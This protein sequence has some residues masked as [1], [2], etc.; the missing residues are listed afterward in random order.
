M[1]TP[2]SGRRAQ[3]ARNDDRI[4]AAARHVFV[5]DPGAPIAAVAERAGVGISALYRRYE[6][7]EA[8]LRKLCGD[9]LRSYIA[10]VE[11]AIA[12]EGDAWEAFVGFMRRVVDADTH[13][14][15]MSLAG[16]FRPT[17]ELYADAATAGRLNEQLVRRTKAAGVLRDDIQ[18]TDFGMIFQMVAAVRLGDEE[19]TAELRHRYL[20]LLLDGL[21]AGD[22]A[23]KQHTSLPG[24]A[25]RIK[26][27]Q[28][29]WQV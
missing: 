27:T 12:D 5:A 18:I 25:P 26:E 4:L 28:E 13:S 15:T 17:E 1:T 2:L 7:K 24:A 3:A 8:L 16:T 14:L 6:S 29:R 19:R 23:D 9:G 11:E 20:A 22:R 21:R 10:H